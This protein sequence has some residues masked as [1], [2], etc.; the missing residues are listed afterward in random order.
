M[1]LPYK[2]EKLGNWQNVSELVDFKIIKL[3]PQSL[4]GTGKADVMFIYKKKSGETDKDQ[5]RLIGKTN[6]YTAGIVT[7]VEHRIS[8]NGKPYG[9]ITI[10]DFSDSI[11]V[12][13]N[14]QAF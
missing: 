3:A 10:E 1:A 7:N 14:R 12:D 2:E 6:L 8:K 4:L 13:T 11:N 9:T 5:K